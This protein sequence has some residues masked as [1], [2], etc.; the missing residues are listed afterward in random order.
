MSEWEPWSTRVV[1]ELAISKAAGV[2]FESAWAF[3]LEL[4]PPYRMDSGGDTPA[5]FVADDLGAEPSLV[6]FVRLQCLREWHGELDVDY[7]AAL[8]VFA[9]EAAAARKSGA[10][11][12][13]AA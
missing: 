3:A 6:E 7:R 9:G 13:R 2:G 12:R 11:D 5:L 8:E 10:A 1:R 4:H